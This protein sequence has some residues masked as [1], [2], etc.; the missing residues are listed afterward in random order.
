MKKNI[1]TILLVLVL[2]VVSVGVFRP[3]SPQVIREDVQYAS[4]QA[5]AREPIVLAPGETLTVTCD[6]GFRLAS[7]SNLTLLNL[8][9]KDVTATRTPTESPDET[10]TVTPTETEHARE[11]VTPS[12]GL[13]AWEV[14]HPVGAHILPDGSMSG[15]HEHGQKQPQWVDDWSMAN[16][17]H[18]L[19]YGGDERSSEME[20]THKH[21][22]YG[23]F[24]FTFTPNGCRLDGYL[25]YHASSTPADRSAKVHSF[26]IY[27]RDCAGNISFN[28]GVYWTGDPANIYQRMCEQEEI[29]IGRDQYIIR[30]RC[31]GDTSLSEQWYTHFIN[32]DFSLT[33]LNAITMYQHGEQ[34]NDP[35]NPETWIPALCRTSPT[36]ST[37]RQ[38]NELTL[39]VE[40]TSL[41]NP[42]VTLPRQYNYPRDAWWCAQHLPTIGTRRYTGRTLPFPYWQIT[43]AVSGPDA[44]PAGY[45]PQY[46]ASTM[47]ALYADMPGGNTIPRIFFDGAGVVE[48]PN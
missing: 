7:G 10:S 14:W 44:C 15:V 6:S 21:E 26:E 16:F 46:N 19:I 48:V 1:N 45:L 47:P 2:L 24:N 11:T 9:C 37:L 41:P 23:G 18:P 25:R 35:M 28:Q 13:Q 39:R 30:G 8:V 32:W 20:I 17:G 31:V 40:I 29:T 42:N 36:N 4:F 12:E 27:V 43:G 22:A 5:G 33:L 3:Q 34:D 38:C